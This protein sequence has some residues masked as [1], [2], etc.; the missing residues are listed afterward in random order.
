MQKITRLNYGPDYCNTYIVGEEGGP[1]VLIDPGYNRDHVLE[2]Y[3]AKHHEKLLGILIT[4]GHYDHIAGLKDWTNLET[5]PVF[6]GEDDIP[7]LEDSKLN[8]SKGLFGQGFSLE[9]VNPYPAEDEDEIKLGNY[10]FTVIATPYHTR[11]GVCY[12]LEEDRQLFSGDS[13]FH[14]GIGRSDL[15][16]SEPSEQANSLH[17]LA[18]LPKETIVYPGHGPQSSIANE[19]AYNSDFH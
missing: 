5:I 7:C 18:I 6:M 10:I 8:V 4:H 14:L 17:K 9:G 19:L 2:K 13:L 3:L 11:G 12:F 15:P 1:V 16:G